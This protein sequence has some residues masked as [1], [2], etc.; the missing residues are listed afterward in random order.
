MISN[1]L[2]G[3]RTLS[4]C[5]ER[6]LLE[7]SSIHVHHEPFGTPYYWGEEAPSRRQADDTPR[8]A[9]FAAVAAD[10]FRA[11]MPAGITHV[12]SKDHA[13]YI[14][15]HCLSRLADFTNGV[16][17]RHSFIIRHPL[18][19]IVS[20]YM[21]ACVD[22]SSTGYTYFDPA[23]AGFVAMWDLYCQIEEAATPGSQPAPIID[24][25]DLLEDPEGV[26]SAYCAAVG[27]PFDV[28]MLQWGEKPVPHQVS[29]QGKSRDLRRPEDARHPSLT[30]ALPCFPCSAAFQLPMVWLD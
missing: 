28:S 18:R 9:S 17:V 27:L 4:T 6:I 14:M 21:K 7:A 30:D 19:A 20:L 26:M 12:F 13:Y 3:R 8:D 5:V 22:N 1:C 15:P 11:P 16:D 23:E 2:C 24:A 25:D 29:C 10:V